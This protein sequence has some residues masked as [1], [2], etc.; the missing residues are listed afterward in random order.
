MHISDAISTFSA[1]PFTTLSQSMQVYTTLLDHLHKRLADGNTNTIIFSPENLSK[2]ADKI[3]EYLQEQ[4]NIQ[5]TG[6]D[7]RSENV[8]N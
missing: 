5:L 6:I 1:Q 4:Q 7:H 3:V 2:T 8:V